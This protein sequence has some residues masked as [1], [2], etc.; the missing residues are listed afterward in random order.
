[1]TLN[2]AAYVDCVDDD[3][4]IF[5]DSSSIYCLGKLPIDEPVTYKIAFLVDESE[6]DHAY[7]TINDSYND[8]TYYVKVK[9]DADEKKK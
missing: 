8:R 7:V 3:T 2:E 4:D 9:G 1:M 6:I 5:R